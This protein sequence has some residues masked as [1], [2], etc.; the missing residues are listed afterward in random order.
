MRIELGAQVRSADGQ[1]IGTIERVILEPETAAVRAVVIGGGS[2]VPHRVEV[3]IDTLI[4]DDDSLRVGFAADEIREW[5]AFEE[6]N[7]RLGDT[8]QAAAGFAGADTLWPA[9]YVPPPPAGASAGAAFDQGVERERVTMMTE[10]DLQTATV[11]QGSPIRGRDGAVIGSLARLT[12]NE[13]TGQLSSFTVAP[14]QM[15]AE[16][17][18]LSATLI[19]AARGGSLIL[20]V[21]IEE[22]RAAE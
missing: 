2:L 6:T 12:F 9:G 13:E 21:D 22:L 16:E 1:M 15:F 5:P 17:T 18:E 7:E 8:D 20:A 4:S 3:Q 14:G 10:R 19:D 11:R